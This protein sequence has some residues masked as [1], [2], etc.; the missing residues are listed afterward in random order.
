MH[1]HQKKNIPQGQS[2]EKHREAGHRK[3]HRGYVHHFSG[4]SYK[5]WNKRERAIWRGGEWRHEKY[6]GR[7]GWWWTT[8]GMLYFYEEPEYPYPQSVS[9]VEYEIPDEDQL[10]QDYIQEPA[11]DPFYY[12]YYCEDPR[13]YYPYIPECPGGWITVEPLMQPH[14]Q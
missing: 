1:G 7:Y 5:H 11:E 10:P 6:M 3:G 12:W 4:H 9:G 13:G 14:D 8:G 2:V